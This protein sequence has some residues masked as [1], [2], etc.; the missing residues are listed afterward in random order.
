MSAAPSGDA[1]NVNEAAWAL[2]IAWP[3][4]ARKSSVT[5]IAFKVGHDAE[6]EYLLGLLDEVMEAK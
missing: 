1:V 6:R 4:P 3:Q 2:R 5:W